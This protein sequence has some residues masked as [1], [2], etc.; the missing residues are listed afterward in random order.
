ML[1]NQG[2]PGASL[3]ETASARVLTFQV[4]EGERR[5]DGGRPWRRRWLWLVAFACL[6]AGGWTIRSRLTPSSVPEVET[7]TFTGKATREVLLDLSGFIV[8]HSKV[9]ISPQV[10]GIVSKVLLPEEGKTVKTGDLLFIIE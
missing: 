5:G 8:P 2:H 7:Y 6:A 4:A 10:G 3:P 9:V 1:H